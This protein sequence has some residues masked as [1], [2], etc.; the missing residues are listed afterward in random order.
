MHLTGWLGELEGVI[1]LLITWSVNGWMGWRM[2]G[3][4]DGWNGNGILCRGNS[5]LGGLADWVKQCSDLGSKR[6]NREKT[7]VTS[8]PK[9]APASAILISDEG[10]CSDQSSWCCP[11]L[12]P[13]SGPAANSF[14]STFKWCLESDHSPRLLLLHPT[15]AIYHLDFALG[16]LLEALNLT[17]H[18]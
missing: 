6:R 5:I 10:R 2:D 13:F 17:L 18:L 16:L 12:L 3:M 1:T 15:Q 4:E 7:G 8:V 9:A 11:L 14:N